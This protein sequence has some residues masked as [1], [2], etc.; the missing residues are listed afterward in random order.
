M[1]WEALIN[2]IAVWIIDITSA[3]DSDHVRCIVN[4]LDLGLIG[5]QVVMDTTH[6]I[7]QV[8]SAHAQMLT[9]SLSLV[10]VHLTV[11]QQTCWRVHKCSSHVAQ[12]VVM[13]LS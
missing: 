2:L 5:D 7:I 6:W 13:I 9:M 4:A 8:P 10:L 1:A 11:A 3:V 12:L